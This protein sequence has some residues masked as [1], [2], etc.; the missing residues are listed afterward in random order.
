MYFN[1]IDSGYNHKE[2]VCSRIKENRQSFSDVILEY[3]V[4]MTEKACHIPL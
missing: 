4:L 3:L 1:Q 2:Y